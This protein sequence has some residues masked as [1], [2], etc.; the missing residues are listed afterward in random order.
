MDGP[1]FPWSR[2][3]RR[4][5]YKGGGR[6]TQERLVL[7][8]WPKCRYYTDFPRLSPSYLW[9][10]CPN[11]R[12]GGFNVGFDRPIDGVEKLVAPTTFETAFCCLT[13]T[14]VHPPP[15]DFPSALAPSPPPAHTG[16]PDPLPSPLSQSVRPKFSV[17]LKDALRRA[18]HVPHSPETAFDHA[19]PHALRAAVG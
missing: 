3:A 13:S 10:L 5:H 12:R 15:P 9:E 4:A 16:R 14:D 11:V 2:T 18:S 17:S 7:D 19:T 1:R 8:W 6:I